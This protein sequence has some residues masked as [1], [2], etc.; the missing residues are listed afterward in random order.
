MKY[1][2]IL[3]DGMADEPQEAAGGLT[4][5]EA[6]DKKA[7]DALAEKGKVGLV[8]TVPPGMKPGS[9]VANMSVLG[10]NPARYYTGRSPLEALNLGIKME[11]QDVA[12]RCNVVCLSEEEECYEDKQMIDFSSGE[13]TTEEAAK[14]IGAI[15][16]KMGNEYFTFYPGVGYRHCMLWKNGK[17]DPDLIPPHDITGQPIKGYLPKD[18]LFLT[19]MKESYQIL[20]DHP[21]N[22]QRRKVGKRPANSIWLWGSGT[23]PGLT[24]FKEKTGKTAAMISAVDLLKGLALGA[25]MRSIDVEG[26]NAL[27]D[28]NYLGKGQAGIDAL[29]REGCDFVYV[30][31]EAPDEM[32]HQGDLKKKILAIEN[33]DSMIVAPMWEALRAS[34]EDYAIMI[35]PDHPTF[36][37]TKTHSDLP[38]PFMIYDSRNEKNNS[39]P[40]SEKGALL[41]D[42]VIEEGYKLMD[43]FLGI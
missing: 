6:A 26:A 28:T 41:S 37:R 30:H 39:L 34:G 35:L 16:E 13:I 22:I 15:E 38:I 12:V 2:L 9:D 23:R 24:S 31:I 1:A 43:Y 27:L 18:E 10:F 29:L 21:V 17:V 7:M 33:I 14:L 3:A 5:M 42:L 25:G 19:M 8:R 40:F 32:G 20:R 36:I 4:P 11:D